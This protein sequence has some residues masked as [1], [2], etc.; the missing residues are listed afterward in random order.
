M[1]WWVAV[2]L[3]LLTGCSTVRLTYGQGP[4]LAYWWL[5]G[6]VDFTTEQAP[7]AKA[8]LE[9]WFAWHRA[10]QLNDYAAWLA[11]AQRLA[12]DNITPAQVCRLMDEGERHVERAFDQAVPSMAEIVRGF[13]PAQLRH[14]EQRYAKGNDDWARDHLQQQPGDRL[15]AETKRWVE[16]SENVY[17]S[18]DA[19][20][21]RLIATGLAASPSDPQRWA[22]E[23]RQRQQDILR[24]L[25][26]LL[27]ERADAAQV[28]AALRAFAVQFSQS[29]RLE[30]RAYRQRLKDANCQLA[31]TLHNSTTA[32]QRQRAVDKLRGW[33]DD[34]RSLARDPVSGSRAPSPGA[35]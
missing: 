2:L 9:D 18:I 10:T 11:T 13:T 31:A 8:A 6:Y 34:L 32:A 17:G 21:R 22:D 29:P 33:E 16:R 27:A 5:D 7:Q 19:A 14:I 1:G 25:R 35:G 12:V 20:Q 3:P 4:M 26:Q 15:A 24:G 30:Y 23:R 28:Q